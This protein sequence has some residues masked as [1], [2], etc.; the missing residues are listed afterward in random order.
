MP[1][2]GPEAPHPIP[3]GIKDNKKYKY[4]EDVIDS[5][6]EKVIIGKAKDITSLVPYF[7]TS[8]LPA[9]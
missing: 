6:E 9:I 8:I 5:N 4:D 7:G 3:A 1:P 2:I